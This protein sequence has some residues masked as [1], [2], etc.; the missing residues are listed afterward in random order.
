MAKTRKQALKLRSRKHGGGK[1]RTARKRARAR[2][3]A[4]NA[5]LAATIEKSKRVKAETDAIMERMDRA[6]KLHESGTKSLM[7]KLDRY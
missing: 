7:A 5:R 3:A 6:S 2:L 1:G 4:D